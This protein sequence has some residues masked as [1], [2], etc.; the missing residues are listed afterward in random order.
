MESNI[1]ESSVM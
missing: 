1:M